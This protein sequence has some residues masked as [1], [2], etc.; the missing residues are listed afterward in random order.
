MARASRRGRH[1]SEGAGG[2]VTQA[3]HGIE[4]DRRATDGR[5]GTVAASNWKRHPVPT[6]HPF[7]TLITMQ[8]EYVY[9]DPL[10]EVQYGV[11]A[12]TAGEELAR[13]KREHRILEP[14]TVVEE[15]RPEEA[16]LHPA[17]EWRDPEAAQ[18]WREHQAAQIIRR[19]R[20]VPVER[21]ESELP[22]ISRAA[23]VAPPEPL[24][25]EEHDPL[26]W[27]LDLAVAALQKAKDQVSALKT[28]AAAR[29]DRKRVI[30]A[31]VALSDLEQADDLLED[32][33]ESLTASRQASRWVGASV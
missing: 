33:R 28:K 23:A 20:V 31:G 13:I 6:G 15:S 32:A 9:S 4:P 27:D 3:W 12:Q 19:V 17:F 8:N 26:V 1:G 10:A 16:P 30:Q 2:L 14:A 5:R 18:Q 24:A 29:F 7:I 21:E 22:R 25:L 11:D